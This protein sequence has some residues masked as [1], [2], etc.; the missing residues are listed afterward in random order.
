MAMLVMETAWDLR[1]GK[2]VTVDDLQLALSTVLGPEEVDA[3]DEQAG[4]TLLAKVG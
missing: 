3:V 4:N 2:L 1:E